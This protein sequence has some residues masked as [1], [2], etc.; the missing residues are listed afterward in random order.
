LL[1]TSSIF[2]TTCATSPTCFRPAVVMRGDDR[3]AWLATELGKRVGVPNC[4]R[5]LQCFTREP[6]G[7][8]HRIGIDLRGSC[9]KSRRA[10]RLGQLAHVAFAPSS[11][12]QVSLREG[13]GGGG[14]NGQWT[15]KAVREETCEKEE[16]NV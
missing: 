3:N 7:S 2:S 15:G 16:G 13:G 8:H 12:L 14:V 6:Y 10:S 11:S 9:C 5:A 1:Q 4:S